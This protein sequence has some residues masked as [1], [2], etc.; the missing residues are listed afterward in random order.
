MN[1]NEQ[2]IGEGMGNTDRGDHQA[3]ADLAAGYALDALEP[4]EARLLE[5]HLPTCPSCREAVAEMRAVAA[6]LPLAV[7]PV[8]PPAHLKR[9]LFARLQEHPRPVTH[10]TRPREEAPA[11]ATGRRGL[12][13][14]FA[15]RLALGVSM[16]SLL[17]ALV[18]G[19]VAARQRGEISDLRAQLQQRQAVKALVDTPGSQV[20]PMRQ[21][22]LRAKLFTVPDRNQAYIVIDG[23]PPLPEGRA[24]QLWLM[25]QGESRPD[26]AGVFSEPTGRW[27]LEADRPLGSY[28]WIGITQEP[29]GGS[30]LPSSPPLM[31]RDL[32]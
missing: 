32:Q 19:A 26:S 1:G 28:G 21:G 16:A 13:G 11:E 15:G 31:G 18:A 2:C 6:L 14:L 30:R 4:E 17:F 7:E 25:L 24:Y 29:A 3:I 5:A 27:L 22:Q 9:E 8:E 20:V 12:W 23:L 10:P